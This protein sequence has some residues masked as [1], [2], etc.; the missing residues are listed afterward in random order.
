M[1]REEYTSKLKELNKD[2]LLKC[3]LLAREYAFHNNPVKT[4]DI[5][6]DHYQILKVEKIHFSKGTSD[7]LPYCIYEGKRLT[8]KLEPFKYKGN[9]S[10]YQTNLYGILKASEDSV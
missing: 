10:S 8:K 5:I 1:D 2:Y 6:E 9:S 4:G 3:K 7:Q